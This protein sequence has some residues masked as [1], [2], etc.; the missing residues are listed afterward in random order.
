[1][2]EDAESIF[3]ECT[4]DAD[5]TRFLLSPTHESVDH[6]KAFLDGCEAEWFERES[7]FPWVIVRTQNSTGALRTRQ[8]P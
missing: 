1:M 5:V 3:D 7:R 8:V 2:V 4:S 6:T